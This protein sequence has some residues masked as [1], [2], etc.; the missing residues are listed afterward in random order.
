MKLP[1]FS[2]H[3]DLN[4]LKEEMGIEIDNNPAYIHPVYFHGDLA[5]FTGHTLKI[6]GGLFDEIEI[7][8][9]HLKGQIRVVKASNQGN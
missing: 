7:L 3:K 8:E 1:D 9:G 6:H 4:K 2:Q 5:R